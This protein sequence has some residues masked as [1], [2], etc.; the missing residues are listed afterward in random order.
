M[1]EVNGHESHNRSRPAPAVY[2]TQVIRFLP[3]SIHLA[4]VP[5]PLSHPS[6]ARSRCSISPF[7][8]FHSH[9]PRQHPIVTMTCTA[10]FPLSLALLML[11]ALLLSCCPSAC[12]ADSRLRRPRHLLRDVVVEASSIPAV[13]GDVR[14]LSSADVCNGSDWGTAGSFDMYVLAQAWSPQY[15]YP[16]SHQ[17]YPGCQQP[18]SWQRVNATLRGLWPQYYQPK[19]GHLWPQCCDSQ[20]GA[21]LNATVVRTELVELRRYWPSEQTPT[22]S[23]LNSSL[24]WYEWS[25]SGTCIDLP[26]LKYIRLALELTQQ[27]PTPQL[28]RDNIHSAVNRSM[29]ESAYNDGQ[30]CSDDKCRVKLQCDDGNY[31]SELHSCWDRLGKQIDC[32]VTMLSMPGRCQDGPVNISAFPQAD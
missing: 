1:R 25:R 28:L 10:R 29:L 5:P 13:R 11:V 26:Q 17:S 20:Y 2:L 22:G 21:S 7:F 14:S 18:T 23:P 8:P 15:C 16:A 24:W 31:L 27:L 9:M 30:P 32:P 6:P 19:G 4:L 3:N 12:S